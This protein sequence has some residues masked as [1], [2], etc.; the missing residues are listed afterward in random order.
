[1]PIR[2]EFLGYTP[3]PLKKRGDLRLCVLGG[4]QGARVFSSV[5]PRALALLSEP[6]RK[7][8]VVVQQVQEDDL[9][10]V[11]A[12][13]KT[14]DI[15]HE[16]FCFSDQPASLAKEVH[17]VICRAGASSLAELAA[18][19]CPVLMVPYPHATDDH[20]RDN[21]RFYTDHRGG[22]CILEEDFSPV[23]CAAFLEDH[24]AKIPELE[25]AGHAMHALAKPNAAEV[26]AS[27]I[28][29]LKRSTGQV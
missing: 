18:L 19:G 15:R 13:Y 22:W 4:S 5:V 6:L 21:A 29:S 26:L 3:P 7:R 20:Q 17:L 28:L 2:P 24:L 10:F 9:P 25:S 16:L 1:M 23:S 14:Q 27:E 8:I 12:F 11:E